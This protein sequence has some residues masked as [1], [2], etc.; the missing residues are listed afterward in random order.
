M[1]IGLIL[2]LQRFVV[3]EYD[4]QWDIL[5]RNV[6]VV[7]GTVIAAVLVSLS[8]AMLVKNTRFFSRLALS[9]TQDATEGFTVQATSVADRYLN[10]EGTAETTFRPSGKI[11]L[12]DEVVPAESEGGYIEIGRPVR[13][14]RV[15]GNRIVVREV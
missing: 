9:D 1:G 10:R 6:L 8:M 15:D 12:E 14:V 4:Y 2:S 13:I 7:G 5:G 11:R 3:P